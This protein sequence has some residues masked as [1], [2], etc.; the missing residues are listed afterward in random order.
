[1]GETVTRE[2]L[3]FID[4]YECGF[5]TFKDSR[6]LEHDRMSLHQDS[7]SHHRDMVV[8]EVPAVL[9]RDDYYCSTSGWTMY[10]LSWG[11]TLTQPDIPGKRQGVVGV[12]VLWR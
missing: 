3:G 7:H 12:P 10:M 1:M 2:S 4:D 9:A 5:R 8:R 11:S 6:Y